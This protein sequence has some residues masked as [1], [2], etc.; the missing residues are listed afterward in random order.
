L[1][2]CAG[3]VAAVAATSNTSIKAAR[4]L[5]ILSRKLMCALGAG[6]RVNSG[7][8]VRGIARFSLGSVEFWQ[9]VLLML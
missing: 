5:P 4:R 6:M 2:V 8:R 1:K 7:K 3:E 9:I